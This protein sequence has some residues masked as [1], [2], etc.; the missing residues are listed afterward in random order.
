LYTYTSNEDGP[1]FVT[2]ID[3]LLQPKCRHT[4]EIF[5]NPQLPLGPSVASLNIRK[6]KLKTQHRG[7]GLHHKNK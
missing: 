3:K 6:K 7:E 2:Q 5:N 4:V 1:I